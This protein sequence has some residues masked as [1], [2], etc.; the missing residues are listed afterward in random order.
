MH[1][2]SMASMIY[3]DF[4]GQVEIEV[5]GPFY[6][7]DVAIRPQVRAIEVACDTKA[8]R[9]KLNKPENLSIEL[10]KDR[11]H[12]LHL[13]TNPIETDVPDKTSDKVCVIKGKLNTPNFCSRGDLIKR[14]KE[15]PEDCIIYF[16][17]GIFYIT[18]CTLHLLSNMTLYLSGGTIIIGS[19]VCSHVEHV[20]IYGRGIFYLADFSRF[21]GLNGIRISYAKHISIEN[22][23]FINPP[24]YTIYIGESEEIVLKNIRSFSCEGWS[25]GI[26]MMSSKKVHIEGGFLRTSDDCIA[27]YG[28]RWP[29]RGNSSDIVVKGIT[30]WADVAHPIMI[31][32]HGDYEHDGDI[33]ER[34]LCHNIDILEHNEYQE[35]YLGCMTINVGDKNIAR[36]IT[37]DTIRIEQFKHGKLL[38]FQVK[39][40]PDYNPAPG[41]SIKHIEVRNIYYDGDGEVTS[42]IK[43]YDIR[44][45]VKDIVFE[46]VVIRK[47]RVDTLKDMNLRVGSFVENIEMQ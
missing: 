18:E 43:G 30:L 19:F 12:N 42:E 29:Y 27:I 33:I 44:Q 32:T 24:H 23:I 17:P 11:A 28:S 46:N 2:I 25:D 31:G 7:Y 21:T 6:I 20:K 37:F 26:D 47:K 40:N 4:E 16:E 8:V 10:N 5:S 35:G 41:K 9:F 3:F 14:L 22:V 38:D 1:D 45:G 13:F 39:C 34:V 36:Y 15:M